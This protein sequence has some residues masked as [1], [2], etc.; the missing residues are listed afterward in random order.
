MKVMSCIPLL[1]CVLG[2]HA[3]TSGVMDLPEDLP[4]LSPVS[5]KLGLFVWF[6]FLIDVP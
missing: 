3:C 4:S 5:L 6:P 1:S 2:V